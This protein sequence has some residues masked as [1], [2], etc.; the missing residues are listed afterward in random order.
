[1]WRGVRDVDQ[2]PDGF[3]YFLVD[4]NGRLEPHGVQ[5]FTGRRPR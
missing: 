2:L 5:M 3:R 4:H 1:M